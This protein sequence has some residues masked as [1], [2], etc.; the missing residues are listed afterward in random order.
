MPCF[1]ASGVYVVATFLAAGTAG[2]FPPC[3]A[4]AAAAGPP[5]PY[6]RTG[7][8]YPPGGAAPGPI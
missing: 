1:S 3:A 4:R 7:A 5:P 2:G 6:P 8:R